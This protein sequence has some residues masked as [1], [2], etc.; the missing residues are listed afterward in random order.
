MKH[1]EPSIRSRLARS[2]AAA[3]PTA[4][5]LALVACGANLG[6]SGA[7]GGG[8]GGSGATGGAGGAL[9]SGGS[10]GASPTVPLRAVEIAVGAAHSCALLEGGEVAC[11]GD[12]SVG[13]LGDGASG[14]GYNRVT[15]K[16]IA[17]LSGATGIRAGGNTTCA[18][19]PTGVVCWGDGSYGQLGDGMAMDGYFRAT[20]APVHGLA[21]V[22]DLAMSSATACASLTDDS[23][24]CWGKN[25]P[26]GWLGF[27]SSDCGPYGTELVPCQTTPRGVMGAPAT[28]AV[29]AGSEHCCALAAD[30]TVSCWGADDFG[31]L[32]DGSA[33]PGV[34][35]IKPVPVASVSGA[36]RLAL[37]DSHTCAI[38]GP[39]GSAACWG[40]NDFGQ[41]GVGSLATNSF[42]SAAAP[43][44]GLQHVVDLD[45]A[46]RVTCAVL[47]DHTV[48][49]WGDLAAGDA[50][51]P[52]ATMSPTPVPGVASAVSVRTS[53]THTCARRD[54]GSVVCWGLN[55]RGQLGNGMIG[56]SDYSLVPVPA[57]P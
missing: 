17:G 20:P 23:V 11:W 51:A 4:L 55:D 3:A 54:D 10:G 24:R 37:G 47:E 34:H 15:A 43:V 25:S 50:G 1:P 42:L 22:T 8:T 16:R 40:D 57:A 30:H 29:G 33:G 31:Q 32:G 18:I 41:L 39:A 21:S 44:P 14:M 49:C 2:L 53:G 48:A 56:L 9:S 7:A 13:Q 27:T 26:G 36:V 45:A 35:S 12:G 52:M 46:G 19:V 6:A 28:I 38:M 5:A